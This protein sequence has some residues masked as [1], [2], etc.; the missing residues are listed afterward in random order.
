MPVGFEVSNEQFVSYYGIKHIIA[1]MKQ[2]HWTVVTKKCIHRFKCIPLQ[3][4]T[5]MKFEN[6]TSV[7]DGYISCIHNS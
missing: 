6:W 1:C 4:Y 7:A 3:V 2:N 5:D